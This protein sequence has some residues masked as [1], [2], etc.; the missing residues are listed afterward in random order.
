MS[1]P[2]INSRKSFPP[3][4]YVNGAGYY[5]WRDPDSKKSHGLGRDKA[6][7][8]AEARSANAL[9]ASRE[10]KTLVERIRRTESKTFA[11]W[12]DEWLELASEGKSRSTIANYKGAYRELKARCGHVLVD[13]ITPRMIDEVLTFYKDAGKLRMGEMVHTTLLEMFRIA[14]VKGLIEVGKNPATPTEPA[15]SEIKRLRLDLAGFMKVHA[16]QKTHWGRLG[17]ELA[18]VSAQRRGDVAQMRRADIVDSHL[19]VDQRKS[20]G[21]TKLGIPLS[22]RLEAVGWSLQ[23]IIDRCRTAGL[24]SPFILHHRRLGPHYAPGDPVQPDGLSEK[25]ADALKLTDIEIEEGRTPP[26]FHEIRSLAIRLWTVQAGK[27]F[28]QALAGHRNMKTT[29]LYTDPRDSEVKR[30]MIPDPN[31]QVIRTNI[32]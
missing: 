30:I 19:Q 6:R 31:A 4:L 26:T 28:A 11:A 23:D 14:E 3:N 32:E 25:F 13:E 29:L 17:M 21:E 15:K 24:I 16:A 22:L 2:R 7:A 27:E 8:F 12:C 10:P 5:S 20:G 18:L 1:R 9:V